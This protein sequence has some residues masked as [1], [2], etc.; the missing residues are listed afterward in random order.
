MTVVPD[1]PTTRGGPGALDDETLGNELTNLGNELMQ[2]LNHNTTHNNHHNHNRSPHHHHHHPHHP[3]PPTSSGMPVDPNQYLSFGPP[4]PMPPGGPSYYYNNMNDG[5]GGG[6][7]FAPGPPPPGPPTMGPGPGSYPMQYYNDTHA[8][9]GPVVATH[10]QGGGYHPHVGGPPHQTQVHQ[11]MS[12]HH[13]HGPPSGP[14][15]GP[16]LPPVPAQLPPHQPGGGHHSGTTESYNQENSGHVSGMSGPGDHSS[17]VPFSPGNM[18]GDHRNHQIHKGNNNNNNFKGKGKG[19]GGGNKGGKYSFSKGKASSLSWSLSPPSREEDGGDKDQDRDEEDS[20]SQPGGP[21]KGGRRGD[22]NNNTA[23]KGKGKKGD[24][25]SA[26]YKRRHN[27][28]QGPTH[29]MGCSGRDSEASFDNLINSHEFRTAGAAA[30]AALATAPAALRDFRLHGK[31]VPLD[32]IAPHIV[33]FAKDQYGS[34]LIQMKLMNATP[35]EKQVLYLAIKRSVDDLILDPFANY[36]IQQFFEHGTTVHRR[37]LAQELHGNVLALSFHMFGCW[38][39]QRAIDHLEGPG[40]DEQV[41]LAKELEGEVLRLVSNQNGNHVIQI[42]IQ[43]MPS[44]QI[45][46]ILDA[47]KG[48]VKAMARHTYGCRVLQRLIEHCVS[49][50]LGELVSELLDEVE[51]LCRDEY[52]NYVIQSI[53]ERVDTPHRDQVLEV[54]CENLLILSTDKYASN[55]CEKALV[56]SSSGGRNSSAEE[57]GGKQ[58]R[59]MIME[60]MLSEAAGEPIFL[61]MMKDKYANYLVQKMISLSDKSMKERLKERLSEGKQ[62][63]KKFTYGKHISMALHKAGIRVEG[64][65]EEE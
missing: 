58:G 24:K 5:H 20:S 19:F 29:S 32:Q 51:T 30:A 65:G 27:L 36:V 6:H 47:F 25:N 3:Q 1:L 53:V 26:A 15:V 16:G 48:E 60:T 7:H 59:Q 63:W 12:M 52:G 11:P 64:K 31:R 40:N 62:E 38:A 28:A 44:H 46:F 49:P 34:R 17:R 18:K 43:K 45:G 14:G 10:H 9:G 41:M 37:G 56:F 33:D 57:E 21:G 61:Q 50:E 23:F 8:G 55:V 22:N 42:C 13:P 54:I 4:P 39:L 35:D 2:T